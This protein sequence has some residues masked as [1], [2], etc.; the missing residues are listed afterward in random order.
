M[1]NQSS[2]IFSFSKSINCNL[3]KCLKSNQ[4]LCNYCVTTTHC[5]VVDVVIRLQMNNIYNLKSTI[6]QVIWYIIFKTKTYSLNWFVKPKNYLVGICVL[7]FLLPLC[8]ICHLKQYFIHSKARILHISLLSYSKVV[9][10]CC[11]R[12]FL[13]SLKR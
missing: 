6:H 8:N 4:I 2:I 11:C 1:S 9:I 12:F 3:N 10:C 13:H 7:F 5:H